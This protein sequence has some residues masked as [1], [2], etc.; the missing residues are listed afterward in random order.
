M[1]AND[2]ATMVSVTKSH[3]SQLKTGG[4]FYTVTF[5]ASS[6]N[7]SVISVTADSDLNVNSKISYVITNKDEQIITQL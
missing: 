4:G 6:A 3:S 7:P 2:G 1:I 5:E